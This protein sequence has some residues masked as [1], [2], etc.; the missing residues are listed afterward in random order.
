M[1]EQESVVFL[2]F[3]KVRKRERESEK[4]KGGKKMREKVMKSLLEKQ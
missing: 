4:K 3:Q 1:F 2:L